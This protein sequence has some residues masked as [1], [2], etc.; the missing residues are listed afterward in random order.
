MN[1]MESIVED[2]VSPEDL[3]K[4][5]AK[6]LSALKNGFVPPTTQFDYSWCLIR[7]ESMSRVREGVK[8]LEDLYK[9]SGEND[10][11]RDYL[12]YLAIGNTRIGEY[13]KA[14]NYTEAILKVE[15]KNSQS[16]QLHEYITKRRNKE[17]L[18]GAAVAGG[19]AV[20]VLGGLIGLGM[21]MCIL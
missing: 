8:L 4:F 7:S 2:R 17:G 21:R 12:F 10:E 6:Y 11:K 14:L 18:I 5:E 1:M 13:N 9:K 15:P 19:A 3:R 20:A 16:H